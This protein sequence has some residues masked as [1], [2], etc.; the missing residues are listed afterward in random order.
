MPKKSI[1][2]D[3][4]VAALTKLGF[5]QRTHR[6]G[7][8]GI[9]VEPITGLV[10]TL[11]MGRKEVPIVYLRAALRQIVDRGMMPEDDFLELLK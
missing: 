9:F 3:R 1:R 5:V 2:L 10:V 11:P 4:L 7:S 8:H 6:L